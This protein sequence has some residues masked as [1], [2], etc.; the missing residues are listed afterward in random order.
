MFEC[1]DVVSRVAQTAQPFRLNDCP[2]KQNQDGYAMNVNTVLSV[3]ILCA[4]EHD[5]STIAVLHVINKPYHAKFTAEDEAVLVR[6]A[7]EISKTFQKR[8][9]DERALSLTNKEKA[10]YLAE[11]FQREFGVGYTKSSFKIVRLS[12]N[13]SSNDVN[14]NG[15]SANSPNAK[16]RASLTCVTSHIDDWSFNPFRHKDHPA[17]LLEYIVAV[18]NQFNLLDEFNVNETIFMNFLKKVHMSYRAN[19][20]HNFLHAFS[21]LHLTYKIISSEAMASLTTI[22]IFALFIAALCHDLDHPGNTK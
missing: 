17:A 14:I 21:V 1:I 22:D 9:L 6:F 20:F 16:S 10:Q 8:I 11:G 7:A 15:F 19:H 5:S 2:T 12:S 18:F 13:V 4:Y 3:P